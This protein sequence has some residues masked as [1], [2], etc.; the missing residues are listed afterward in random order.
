MWVVRRSG[1]LA[2]KEK[3]SVRKVVRIVAETLTT[4][5]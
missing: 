4:L 2:D 5:L 1:V 3:E